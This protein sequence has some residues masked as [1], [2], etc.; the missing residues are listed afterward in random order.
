MLE[1]V[2][3]LPTVFPTM[4]QKKESLSFPLSKGLETFTFRIL[5]LK[6][7]MILTMSAGFFVVVV[8][9]GDSSSFG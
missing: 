8:L 2:P 4:S 3:S 9:L 5:V 6:P 1:D 7:E